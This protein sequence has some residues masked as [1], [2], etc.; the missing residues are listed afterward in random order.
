M[1]TVVE[2][3]DRTY[4]ELSAEPQAWP[5]SREDGRTRL[6]LLALNVPGYYSLPVRLLALQTENDAELRARYD[7]RYFEAFLDNSIEDHLALLEAWQPDLLACSVNIWN[8]DALLDLCGRYR[9]S[10][11]NV[12]VIGGGQEVSNS[13]YNFLES[14]VEFD[15]IVDGEGE[16]PFREF[17]NE[18]EPG[19]LRLRNPAAVSGLHYRNG[20]EVAFTCPGRTIDDLDEIVSTNLASLAPVGDDKLKMGVLLEGTRAC[21]FRCAFCFEGDKRTKTRFSST[22]RLTEEAM[23]LMDLGVKKFHMLDP[24]ICASRPERLE[25]IARLFDR[26]Q[27][28]DPEAF[29]FVEAYA[30]LITPEVADCLRVCSVLDLGLQSVN[31]LTTKSIR[32]PFKRDRWLNG[33]EL[34]RER[35]IPFNVY[36]ISGLPHETFDTFLDGIQFVLHENPT[37]IFFNE[38]CLLNGT[39][40]RMRAD[41]FGYDYDPAPPYFVFGNTWMPRP[42][43]R[44]AQ[45]LSKIVERNH[46]YSGPVLFPYLPWVSEAPRTETREVLVDAERALHDGAYFQ[47]CE[48]D[49][50]AGGTDVHI[51]CGLA[52]DSAR[53]DDLLNLCGRLQ[54]AGAVRMNLRAAPNLLTDIEKLTAL[55][56]RLVLHFR[57]LYDA[58]GH[59]AAD[60]R[61]A[62]DALDR[63]YRLM[64]GTHARPNVEIILMRPPVE[65]LPELIRDCARRVYLISIY[66][67]DQDGETGGLDANTARQLFEDAMQRQAWLRLPRKHMREVLVALGRELDGEHGLEDRADAITEKLAVL[68]FAGNPVEQR[69]NVSGAPVAKI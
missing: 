5:R 57:I 52:F 59:E 39:E 51:D 30:D 62:V 18:W 6:L 14:H 11:P 43:L 22:E 21:P 55:M 12:R 23:H 49:I 56:N 8:R 16:I 46:N 24:I 9:V 69:S 61:A 13:C 44:M 38:L 58:S 66:D 4:L 2:P 19:E 50:R 48:N 29:I 54:F 31:P 45:T 1:N 68:G 65:R 7:V 3:L 17:L 32:R 26:I 20:S 34:L 41:E 36:L 64:R 35:G 37:R 25:G 42:V 67:P 53:F 10:N 27:S 47:E 15:Y 33:V 60:L 28:R 63:E 40:L